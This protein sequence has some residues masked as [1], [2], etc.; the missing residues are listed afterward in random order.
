MLPHRIHWIARPDVATTKVK[1]VDFLVDGRKLWVEHHSLYYYGDDGNY[2]VTSFLKPG[3][4]TFTV[5][6]LTFDGKRARDTVKGR[7]GPAPAPPP[8][9]AGTWKGF[10][11]QAHPLPSPPSGY[12]RF[13]IDRVG[14]HIYDTAG[15]GNLIDVTYPSDGLVEVRTG[16]ATGH[17]KFDLNGWCNGAPGSPARYRCSVQGTDLNFTF[18]G[19]KPCP[20]FTT[21]L[22]QL[23]G[24]ANPSWKRVG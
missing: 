20:G 7:V 14:W 10:L 23:N 3:N 6:V 18:A 15:R 24:S 4:H 1:E 9:L 12:W 17:P 2:L 21:F 11:P 16:M 5:K 19:G 13:V 8:A 22:V